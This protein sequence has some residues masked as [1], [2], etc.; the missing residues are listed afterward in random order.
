M[1]LK[2]R[3][4][5]TGETVEI[6][7][8]DQGYT[9]ETTEEE[10]KAYGIKLEAVKLPEAKKDFVLLPHRWVVER[11][12]GWAARRSPL[13]KRLRTLAGKDCWTAFSGVRGIDA[14]TICRSYGS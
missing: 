11:S 13:G 6:A 14:Q 3:L 9:G 2:R 8:V 7:Y 4:Q 5:V 10:A 12:F 1:W